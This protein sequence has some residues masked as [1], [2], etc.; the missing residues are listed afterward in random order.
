MQRIFAVIISL[1]L[2][3]ACGPSQN[4]IV[5]NS[6]PTPAQP[7]RLY[8]GLDQQYQ[9]FRPNFEGD[10][11]ELRDPIP[12]ISS[13]AGEM[14]FIVVNELS[15]ADY[16]LLIKQLTFTSEVESASFG[17]ALLTMNLVPYR[18]DLTLEATYTLA[19]TDGVSGIQR[20]HSGRNRIL[21]SRNA[22]THAYTTEHEWKSRGSSLVDRNQ[23]ETHEIDIPNAIKLATEKAL[24]Q[25][26]EEYIFE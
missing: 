8:I 17:A 3:T 15:A 20:H 10:E 7:I 1:G 2:L 21:L 5:K 6:A 4:T 25:M 9:T 13:A 16:T 24:Q 11:R 23:D 14:G 19:R 22:E 26:N 12:P 18:L